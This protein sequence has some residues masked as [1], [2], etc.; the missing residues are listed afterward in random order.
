MPIQKSTASFAPEFILWASKVAIFSNLIYCTASEGSPQ[1]NLGLKI[2]SIE[3]GKAICAPIAPF[4]CVESCEWIDSD[5][6]GGGCEQSSHYTA[7]RGRRTYLSG[8]VLS[9]QSFLLQC[10]ASL[11]T[12]VELDHDQQPLCHWAEEIE[13]VVDRP[14]MRFE[15]VLG[16]MEYY[17]N[18]RT[19]RYGRSAIKLRAEVCRYS[20]ERSICERNKMSRDDF[21]KYSLLLLRLQRTR[22]FMQLKTNLLEANNRKLNVGS[23]V[24]NDAKEHK[25]NHRTDQRAI[26]R[27]RT[28]SIGISRDEQILVNGEVFGDVLN[29]PKV[30]AKNVE[31]FGRRFWGE[32]EE[33]VTPSIILFANSSSTQTTPFLTSYKTT[34]TISNKIMLNNTSPTTLSTKPFFIESVDRMLFN[35][36]RG[37]KA[38]HSVATL[39]QK[40]GS[41]LPAVQKAEKYRIS[42]TEPIGSM[43]NH[44]V[45][46]GPHLATRR[47]RYPPQFVDQRIVDFYQNKSFARSPEAWRMG[48]PKGQRR[49]LWP[50]LATNTTKEL[51]AANT[52]QKWANEENSAEELRGGQIRSG[53]AGKSGPKL[54]LTNAISNA[55]T[56]ILQ[57]NQN[58]I[59]IRALSPTGPNLP[60]FRRELRIKKLSQYSNSMGRTKPGGFLGV[61]RWPAVERSEKQSASTGGSASGAGGSFAS[62]EPF[63]EVGQTLP[64]LSPVLPNALPQ[65][66]THSLERAPQFKFVSLVERPSEYQ[67]KHFVGMASRA[68]GRL[69]ECCQQQSPGCR[70]ICRRDVNKEQVKKV[71]VSGQC[72]PVT[73]TGVIQCFPRFFNISSVSKC[74]ALRSKFGGNGANSPT[75]TQNLPLQCLGLCAPNF[76]LTFAHLACVEHIEHILNCYRNLLEDLSVDNKN[77]R[78]QKQ[79]QKATDDALS[80][81]PFLDK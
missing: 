66:A 25:N 53:S 30:G 37:K 70:A 77:L 59:K 57:Q 36:P 14:N 34:K 35:D 24:A 12:S 73:M 2:F 9:E 49:R 32:K 17:R 65:I 1:C 74:C 71:M 48:W 15:K 68:E 38:G 8:I 18:L 16:Q 67:S 46:I 11:A 40:D 72:P 7:F 81:H 55:T 29:G 62:A 31:T 79:Q 52:D 3:N 76:H 80:S 13:T 22:E 5:G 56:N 78:P 45:A 20:S 27:N 39:S 41:E 54:H 47:I 60:P 50:V 26:F 43:H 63:E 69:L 33:I 64:T 4:Q 21:H 44:D 28:N 6:N 61:R 42:K 75:K 51:V 19:V 58:F 10:C 23:S